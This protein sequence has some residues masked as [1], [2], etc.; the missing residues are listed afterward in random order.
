MIVSDLPTIE[1]LNEFIDS[2]SAYPVKAD[3]LAQLAIAEGAG[4]RIIDFYRSFPRDQ[5]FRDQAD[6]SGRSEQIQVLSTE[7]SD[8]PW[9]TLR[10]PQE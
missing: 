2:V 7:E 4:R 5:V 10:S 9:E 3:E 8:Q 6:L 1:E